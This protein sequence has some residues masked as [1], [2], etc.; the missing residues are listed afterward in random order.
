MTLD[1]I[2]RASVVKNIPNKLLQLLKEQE[3]PLKSEQEILKPRV[4]IID[5]KNMPIPTSETCLSIRGP[6]TGF[7]FFFFNN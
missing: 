5:T 6:P 2:F 4:I 3:M 1:N 7:F